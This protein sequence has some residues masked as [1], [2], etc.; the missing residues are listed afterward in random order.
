[1]RTWKSELNKNI[2]YIVGHINT[3]TF[4]PCHSYDGW[5]KYC[6]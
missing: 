1:M 5:N 4:A 3:E 2:C 6:L